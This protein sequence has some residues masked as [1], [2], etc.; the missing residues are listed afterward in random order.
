MFYGLAVSGEMMLL[1]F[2]RGLAFSTDPFWGKFCLFAVTLQV[3]NGPD[4]G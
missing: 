2:D 1:G 3:T 4:V